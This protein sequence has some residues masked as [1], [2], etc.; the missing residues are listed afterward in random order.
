M[1][2]RLARLSALALATS[3]FAF[4]SVADANAQAAEKLTTTVGTP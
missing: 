4:G 3:A 1:T 2:T